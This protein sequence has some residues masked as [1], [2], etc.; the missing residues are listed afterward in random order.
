MVLVLCK[1]Y[2]VK[3]RELE[4]GPHCYC[5]RA[6]TYHFYP[7]IGVMKKAEY[8]SLSFCVSFLRSLISRPSAPL[9]SYRFP[10]PIRLLRLRE[11]HSEDM[12]A[13]L[14]WA[15]INSNMSCRSSPSFR[16][17]YTLKMAV[18]VRRHHVTIRGYHLGNGT[19]KKHTQ[20]S[21]INR[22]TSVS[23]IYVFNHFGINV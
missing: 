6:A 17:F 21:A 15:Q 22:F 3:Y 14:I 5:P 2:K 12:A 7:F 18:Y 11:S 4:L 13:H 9:L 8:I 23:L 10:N 19:R 20:P 16:C 1:V